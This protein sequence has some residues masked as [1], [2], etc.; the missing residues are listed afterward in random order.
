MTI[1]TI[2]ILAA[3]VFL[4]NSLLLLLVFRKVRQEKHEIRRQI[5][6]FITSPDQGKTASPLAQWTTLVAYGFADAVFR[7]VKMG[8]LGE[9]AGE[10]K[11][12]KIVHGA[13]AQAA[14]TEKYPWLNVALQALGLDKKVKN[15]PDL[16]ITAARMLS[17]PLGKVAN[18]EQKSDDNGGTQDIEFH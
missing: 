3:I 8:E 9:V 11:R 2:L 14:V 5:Q 16:A 10:A 17:G 7:K 15:N 18:P 4:T 13:M 6:E 12:E 1:T